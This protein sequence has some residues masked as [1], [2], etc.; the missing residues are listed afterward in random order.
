[1]HDNPEASGEQFCG[2]VVIGSQARLRIWCR[3]AYGFESLRP[4]RNQTFSKL[5]PV[6]QRGDAG[7]AAEELDKD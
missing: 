7:V 1:M 6:L 3:K 5:L 2:R 4:H